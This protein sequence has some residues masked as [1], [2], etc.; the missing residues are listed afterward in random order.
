MNILVTGGAGYIGSH[1]VRGLVP[2]GHNVFVYDNLAKGHRDAVRDCILIEGDLSELDKL[3]EVFT[4]Y[5]IDAVVH[6][7][8]DS[9]VGES[10]EDPAKYY[11]NNVINGLGLLKVMKQRGVKKL[12]FSSSAAV[13]GEPLKI[14][15]TEE[16][17]ENPTNVYGR[18]KLIFEQILQDYDK[19]YGLKFIS[20]RYF[21]ASGA[22]LTG[23]IGEDHN[24]ESHLIP[25]VI[26]VAL[27]QREQI[28]VF[29]N[30]Y[31][32]ADGTCI[33]DY[34]HVTD[35]AEAHILAIEALNTGSQSAVYNLGN[36][37]GFSVLEVIKKTEEVTGRSLKTV[38]AGRRAG[39]P[40]ILI[41]GSQKIIKELNW[42][43]KFDSLER[44][45]ETAWNWHQSHP[46]G[47]NKKN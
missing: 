22:D 26:Q 6:M 18:T 8:A 16:E 30:D 21:N 27:G 13:Y 24:P 2:K 35:L 5:K 33:R 38:I 32:T 39:D 23:E 4:K 31:P 9:L 46:G 14:P 42:Q 7:A 36:G 11:E 3:D 45:I 43:P 10:M 19:A 29:G 34:I 40:A 37:K 25:L 41:A 17:Q 28:T 15:I 20:L 1:I 12:V 47:Y 44:I